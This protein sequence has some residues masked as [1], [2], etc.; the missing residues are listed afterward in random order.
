MVALVQSKGPGFV[1]QVQRY[2][3]AERIKPRVVQRA[4]DLQTVIALVAAGV[5]VALVSARAPVVVAAE[6]IRWV[7][8]EHEA[9]RWRIGV[10]W[11]G[12]E[13][14]AALAAFLEV[15]R[16]LAADGW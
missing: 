7:P 4:N 11:G 8:I 5:G 3:A 2:L 13:P 12:G 6:R 15:T 1:D 16:D 9:A 14:G 10:V